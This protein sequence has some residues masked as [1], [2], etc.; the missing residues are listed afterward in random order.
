MI[1]NDTLAILM[2]VMIPGDR[3]K[4]PCASVALS[5]RDDLFADLDSVDRDWLAIVAAGIAA[6]APQD[7]ARGLAAHEA[8]APQTFGRVL[9]A[10]YRAY[11]TAP[12][13]RAVV[14]AIAESGP[15]EPSPF[16]DPTLVAKV[17]ATRA[18]ARR[19]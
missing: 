19:L 15:R 14:I 1:A 18:A 2:D 16:V 17:V 3:G 10:L 5:S 4:W 7:R 6:A 11:Y 9:A 8:A 13:V 12:A